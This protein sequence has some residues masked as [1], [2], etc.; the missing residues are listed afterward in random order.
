MK[1]QIESELA[2][3]RFDIK[4]KAVKNKQEE[5]IELQRMVN[6]H[7]QVVVLILMKWGNRSSTRNSKK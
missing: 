6:L 7:Y 1:K 2:R 4:R 3:Q 5:A